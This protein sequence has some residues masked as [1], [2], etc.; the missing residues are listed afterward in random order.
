[1]KFSS[2]GALLTVAAGLGTLA[3]APAAA[4]SIRQKQS[5]D[6]WHKQDVCAHEAFVKFPD[7]TPQ[8]NAGRDRAVAACEK[9]NRLPPRT[10]LETSPVKRMPD[11]E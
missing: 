3:A 7:Y 11:A 10:P 9:K 8:A 6:V 4:T 2:L 5:F 1:M